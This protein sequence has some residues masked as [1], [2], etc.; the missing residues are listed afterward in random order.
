MSTQNPRFRVFYA[1]RPIREAKKTTDGWE[2]TGRYY[3]RSKVNAVN[4]MHHGWIAFE[5]QQTPEHLSKCP[6]CKQLLKD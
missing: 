3:W 4:N 5:D 6:A 1:W 2:F